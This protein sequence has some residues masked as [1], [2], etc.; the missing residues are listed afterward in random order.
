MIGLLT[1]TPMATQIIHFEQQHELESLRYMLA[2]IK[3]ASLLSLFLIVAISFSAYIRAM[4]AA[5]F[6]L[7]SLMVL[8]VILVS[9]LGLAMK[10]LIKREAVTLR[11]VMGF[12]LLLEA[13][14]LY[15]IISLFL[16]TEPLTGMTKYSVL[17][18]DEALV[19]ILVVTFAIALFPKRNWML[20][21]IIPL[22]LMGLTI[23]LTGLP[24]SP[25]FAFTKFGCF[26][27]I[28]FTGRKVLAQ[29][30]DMAILRDVEKQMLVKQF[31]RMALIDVLTNL[32]NR[33]HFDQVLHQEIRA[34]TR[35]GRPLSLILLDVDYFKRLNDSQG[36]LA[37]DLCLVQL[38]AILSEIAH[39]PRDLATRYGGEEFALILPETDLKGAEVIAQKLKSVIE[40]TRIPH[41][42]SDIAP[43]VTVS[44]GVC[45]WQEGVDADAFMCSADKLLYEAKK[46]G[47]NTFKVGMAIPSTSHNMASLHNI[48]DVKKPT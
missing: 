47:R 1:L 39:R 43:Y 45:Q 3:W 28:I 37:G 46:A 26:F 23:R 12:F 19:D 7:F 18:G 29:W 6:D 33:R 44:Q 22:M 17:A 34:S 8:P 25:V 30:F 13:A 20:A 5:R 4:S 41:A 36:H 15:L 48:S 11:M 14:W 2:S 24:D 27:V 16:Q 31:Q 32:S 9:L 21:F 10:V 40:H 42:D 38:A 35:N